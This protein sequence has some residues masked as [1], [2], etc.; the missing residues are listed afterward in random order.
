MIYRNIAGQGLNI[1]EGITWGLVSMETRHGSIAL[2]IQ[3]L[4]AT[5]NVMFHAPR[6]SY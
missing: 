6:M 2:N 4:F 5:N 3:K 1:M